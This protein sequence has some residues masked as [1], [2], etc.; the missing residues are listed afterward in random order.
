MLRFILITLIFVPILNEETV[1]DLSEGQSIEKDLEL[2]S[3]QIY[4]IK[5]SN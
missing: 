3:P 2:T 4:E 5:Y 1:I